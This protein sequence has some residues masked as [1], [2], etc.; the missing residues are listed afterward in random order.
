MITEVN[1]AETALHEVCGNIDTHHMKWYDSAVNWHKI[2]SESSFPR[3]YTQQT[4][5]SNVP[6]DSLEDYDRSISDPF[7][8]E[9]ISRVSETQQKTT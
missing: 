1:V 6:T 9:M 3:R 4:S 2:A 5:K 8:D 7:L